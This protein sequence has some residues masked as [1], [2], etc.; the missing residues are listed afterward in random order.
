M[1]TPPT[2]DAIWQRLGADLAQFIRRR[3]GDQHT[4]DDLLQETFL[5][6]Q[7]GLDSLKDADRVAGWVYQIARNVIAEHFRRQS[8][9]LQSLAEEVAAEA[10]GERDLVCQAGSWLGTMVDEL[11][12]TY[13]DAVRM[14]EL[15]GLSQQE[16]ADR[17]GISLSAAKQRVQRGREQLR[18]MLDR[19]CTFE[20]DHRGN[21]VDYD[22]LPHRTV[23]RDCGEQ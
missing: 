6:I 13:R 22:P 10:D 17:L 20:R 4:A 5:R 23:C 21:V 18:Q 2:T 7:R 19:C 1:S 12:E 8:S 14:A 16:A 9:A 3:V 15:E 11:P